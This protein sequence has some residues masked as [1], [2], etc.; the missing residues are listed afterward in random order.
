MNLNSIIISGRLGAKPELK[1]T[2]NKLAILNFSIAQSDRQQDGTFKPMWFDVIVFNKAAE[3]L[4]PLLNKGD[5]VIVM[6]KIQLRS[7]VGR[8]GVER[9]VTEI[10]ANAVK[11]LEKRETNSV[12][13]PQEQSKVDSFN[14]F[15]ASAPMTEMEIPF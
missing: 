2:Q 14:E 11:S 3:A 12:D 15:H 6:G 1:Y 9:R 10:I 7:Y 13:K 4:A 5:E 8:D